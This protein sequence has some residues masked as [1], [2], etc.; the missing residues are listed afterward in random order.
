MT[1]EEMAE[2]VRKL[3]ERRARTRASTSV[4]PGDAATPVTAKQE[5]VSPPSRP[6]GSRSRRRRK[7]AAPVGRVLTAGLAAS[8]GLAIVA[9]IAVTTHPAPAASAKTASA[10]RGVAATAPLPPEV[11]APPPPPQVIVKVVRVIYRPA[12]GGAN[13]AGTSA[14][15]VPSSIATPSRGQGAASSVVTTPMA[16]RPAAASP[17]ARPAAAAPAAAAPA[18]VTQTRGS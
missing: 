17:A 2:R 11:A 4:P 10:R 3:N 16:A 15:A 18:P 6:A 7:H 5:P 12:P 9:S 14:G 1:E 13:S 8:T